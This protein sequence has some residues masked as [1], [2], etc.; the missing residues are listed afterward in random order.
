MRVIDEIVN[1][2]VDG[3]WHTRQELMEKTK[4]TEDE[5]S[6]VLNFL[7]AYGFI[8]LCTQKPQVKA[9]ESILK[10]LRELSPS[11]CRP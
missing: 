9:T 10:F 6:K 11:L 3:K 8:H 1:T 5:L 4:L 7:C 2:L